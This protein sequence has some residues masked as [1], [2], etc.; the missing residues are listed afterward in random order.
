MTIK[1]TRVETVQWVFPRH[2]NVL[3]TLYGGRM[4]AWITETGSLAASRVA[5]GPV[6]L[7]SMDDV[8]F[9]TPVKVGDIVILRGQVEYIGKSS[10]EIGVYV[11]KE[12][13]ERDEVKVA[14]VAHLAYVAVNERARPRPVEAKLSP[15]G[16][17]ERIYESALQRRERRLK[18]IRERRE[19]GDDELLREEEF[20][21]K[22]TYSRIVFPD[23]AYF[24]DVMFA[25]RLL[26]DL[27]QA[28]AI[29]ARRFTKGPVV[30]ASMDAMDFY[31][32][33]YVG[34]IL[35]LY[36]AV[37]YM[38][39]TSLEIGVKVIAEDPAKG[40]LRHTTTSYLTFVHMGKDGKPKPIEVKFEPESPHEKSIWEDALK[41]K[42]R[43]L[44]RV[45]ELL[46][47]IERMIYH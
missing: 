46:E 39:R 12:E 14:T 38:G 27:D 36:L 9:I 4:M 2:A 1:E 32:P 21:Y 30:T 31:K 6:V 43:R 33:I 10:M 13:P 15:S 25:G 40:E 3:G 18:R 42:E 41:R 5:K 17:E 29:L 45:K 19:K 35:N 7:A 26:L 28:A 11:F 47:E 24:G 22:F 16:D 8:D 37:N 23:D 34:D 20:R 44:K